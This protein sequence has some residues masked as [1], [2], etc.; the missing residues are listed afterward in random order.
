MIVDSLEVLTT[1]NYRLTHYARVFWDYERPNPLICTIQDEASHFSANDVRD[2]FTAR[3]DL[4]LWDECDWIRDASNDS[5]S[6]FR[7]YVWKLDAPK[8]NIW[9]NTIQISPYFDTIFRGWLQ[10]ETR[11]SIVLINS[12][13]ND[14]WWSAYEKKI[15]QISIHIETEYYK[16][17]RR[18]FFEVSETYQKESSR[19]DNFEQKCSVWRSQ[20]KFQKTER[21][22]FWIDISKII[23]IR[24]K[25]RSV[26]DPI[27]I[28]EERYELFDCIGKYLRTTEWHVTRKFIE[29]TVELANGMTQDE[30]RVRVHLYFLTYLH[31][32]KS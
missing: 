13:T 4:L 32:I 8:W 2:T 30:I 28:W 9:L 1:S 3:T 11:T 25:L 7:I 6:H 16:W 19:L 29:M 31:I 12:R 17:V 5:S 14:D 22:A 20:R 27:L 21:R 10:N 18:S 24:V 26:L 23:I 15:T